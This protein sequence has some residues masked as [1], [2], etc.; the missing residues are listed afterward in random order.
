MKKIFLILSLILILSLLVAG[1]NSCKQKEGQ[2]CEGGKCTQVAISC[3]SGNHIEF[4]G[5]NDMCIPQKICVP[6]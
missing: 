3:L 4:V 1:C 5:C 2:C 6:D